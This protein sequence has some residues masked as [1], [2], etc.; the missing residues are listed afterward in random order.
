VH[1]APKEDRL[2]GTIQDENTPSTTRLQENI[3]E[4]I[5]GNCEEPPQLH[6]RAAQR[7]R[8]PNRRESE[9]FSFELNGLR[10]TATVSLFDDGRIAELFVNAQKPGTA[11]D[12]GV[13]DAAIIL[14]FALQ[15]GADPDS[16]RWALCR[17]SQGQA[18]GPIGCALDRIIQ[19]ERAH[20][21]DVPPAP[22]EHSRDTP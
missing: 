3:S 13:R 1:G 14:S 5:C 12:I 22:A 4:D 17:D 15:H 21:G 2:G 9:S 11:V 7:Q 10:L 6:K 19:Q 16:I 8:L 20:V 18:L